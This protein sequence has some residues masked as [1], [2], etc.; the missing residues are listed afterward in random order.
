MKAL[1]ETFNWF[2]YTKIKQNSFSLPKI[3]NQWV[4]M[5]MHIFGI[6]SFG[7]FRNSAICTYSNSLNFK[8]LL[9]IPHFPSSSARWLANRIRFKLVFSYWL[10]ILSSYFY[11]I[12]E[13]L[14]FGNSSNL[15]FILHRC[16]FLVFGDN[17]GGGYIFDD[18][19]EASTKN[20]VYTWILFS[21]RKLSS[22]E[23]S[24]ISYIPISTYI[25]IHLCF[26]PSIFYIIKVALSI[27]LSD[28]QV[29]D[30][31]SF[32]P[33][34]FKKIWDKNQKISYTALVFPVNLTMQE[35]AIFLA[36]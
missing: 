13:S 15:I 25:Y 4:T 6:W 23:L 9:F 14:K 2:A 35:T 26:I 5:T 29:I 1:A 11:R 33:P 32:L 3:L 28:Y 27:N 19:I 22:I 21:S 24:S 7:H 34:P 16:L 36:Q 12:P 8:P 10:F 18:D 30:N 20:W 17:F 31:I